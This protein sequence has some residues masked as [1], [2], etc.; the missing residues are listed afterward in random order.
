LHDEP[1][2]GDHE[3]TFKSSALMQDAKSRHYLYGLAKS[4]FV[5][6]EEAVLLQEAFDALLLIGK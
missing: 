5:G 6:K 2:R 3:G 1:C 4:H